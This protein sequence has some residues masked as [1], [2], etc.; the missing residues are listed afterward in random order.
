MDVSMDPT[1]VRSSKFLSLVLRHKPGT[2]GLTLDSEGW[3]DVAELLAAAN[4]TG[5]Q[6]DLELLVRVVHEND[7]QRFTFSDDGKRI[8]ANQGHSIDVDLGLTRLEP[9]TVLYHGTVA[10]FL[11]SIEQQGLL[12]QSRQYVHLSADRSTASIVGS[13]RGKPIVLTVASGQMKDDHFDFFRSKNGVWLTAHVPPKYLSR[14][15]SILD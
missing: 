6:L 14:N 8:R 3:A 1:I 13:R 2:I 11:E 9:P 12:P 5:N 4:A 15:D 10:R 7:K